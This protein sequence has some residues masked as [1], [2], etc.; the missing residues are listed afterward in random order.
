MGPNEKVAY[1]SDVA[2]EAAFQQQFIVVCL[3]YSIVL[4][5]SVL[6]V[7]WLRHQSLRKTQSSLT[8]VV[9]SI[10]TV[11]CATVVVIGFGGLSIDNIA[12]NEHAHMSFLYTAM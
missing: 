4:L 10:L 12:K 2:A 8:Y 7:R 9:I 11:I 3:I 6:G 5:S 1:V